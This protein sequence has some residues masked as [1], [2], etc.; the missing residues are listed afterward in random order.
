M[1]RTTQ[2]KGFTLIELLV[3]IAIIGILAVVV[4]ASLNVAREK[5]RDARRLADLKEVQK[6]LEL[7]F[8]NVGSYP[9][10]TIAN[11]REN[12]C[13]S[14]G[15]NWDAV[16]QWNTALNLLVSSGYLPRLPDDP[17]NQGQIG[18]SNNPDYCYGYHRR[19]STSIYDSCISKSNGTIYNPADYE[20]ILYFSLENPDSHD[21][22]LRWSDSAS[23]PMN[24]C[25]LGPR[26]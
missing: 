5:S 18:G 12:S 10:W 6:A 11:P 14:G 8:F 1:F 3:V 26:R 13:F 21:I 7:Y 2:Q 9:D 22:E 15:G 25:I 17:M 20:Y 4:I 24:S 23:K 16:A 19:V